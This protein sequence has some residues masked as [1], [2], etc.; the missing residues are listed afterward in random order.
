MEHEIADLRARLNSIGSVNLDALAELEQLDARYTSLS[1]QHQDLATAK[2]NEELAQIT[3]TRWEKIVQSGAVAKQDVDEKIGDLHAKQAMVKSA[4]A[5]VDRLLAMKNFA[6][7]EAPFDGVVT[8]I[9]AEYGPLPTA[10]ELR[11]R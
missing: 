9:S 7:L 6:R 1:A 8:A 10:L 4:Q 2:A 11:M 5:N 3:A